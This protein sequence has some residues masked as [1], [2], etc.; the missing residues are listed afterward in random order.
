MAPRLVPSRGVYFLSNAAD[1]LSGICVGRPQRR[2]GRDAV[3]HGQ[4][5]ERL[6]G[7]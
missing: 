4:P 2:R 3:S 5:I 6:T 7:S 1:A